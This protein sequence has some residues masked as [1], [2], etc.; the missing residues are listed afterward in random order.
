MNDVATPTQIDKDSRTWAMLTHISALSGFLIPLGNIIAPLVIW[1]LKREQS[2]FVDDQGKEVLSFQISMLIYFFVSFLLMFILIGIPLMI[3]L[4]IFDLVVT[5]IAAIKA[6]DGVRYR[7]PL[8]I[9]F[10]K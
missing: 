2:E 3:G 7:Y 4:G 8:R 1:L 6:N 9:R 5:I 10:I